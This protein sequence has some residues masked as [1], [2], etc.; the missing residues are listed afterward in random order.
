MN[1]NTSRGLF[2]VIFLWMIIYSLIC[3]SAASDR[4]ALGFVNSSGDVVVSNGSSSLN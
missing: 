2:R 3:T 1:E 4:S